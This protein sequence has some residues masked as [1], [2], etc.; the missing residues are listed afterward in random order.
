MARRAR[1]PQAPL[2]AS[3]ATTLSAPGGPP[4]H[5]PAGSRVR[6]VESIAEVTAPVGR[7]RGSAPNK[8]HT[9]GHPRP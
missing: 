6:D 2:T 3:D 9:R 7:T 1:P 5:G 8:G 4:T